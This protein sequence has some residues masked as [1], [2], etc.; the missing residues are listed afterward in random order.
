MVAFLRGVRLEGLIL[1]EPKQRKKLPQP[2]SLPGHWYRYNS[3]YLNCESWTGLLSLWEIHRMGRVALTFQIIL[4]IFLCSDNINLY[5][6]WTW[7]NDVHVLDHLLEL[8]LSF[9]TILT[10]SVVIEVTLDMQV[11]YITVSIAI[12]RKTVWL[13]YLWLWYLLSSAML[14]HLDLWFPF[15]RHYPEIG[16]SIT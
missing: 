1:N 13:T 7:C 2:G 14:M 11:V 3:I 16:I 9:F 10:V 6:L 8:L 12:H 5:L 4:R 15:Q